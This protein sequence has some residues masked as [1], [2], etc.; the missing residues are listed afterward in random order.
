M[1]LN[2]FLSNCGRINLNVTTN[3]ETLNCKKKLQYIRTQK[4]RNARKHI[5]K[6]YDYVSRWTKLLV[7]LSK[8]NTSEFSRHDSMRL[9]YFTHNIKHSHIREITAKGASKCASKSPSIQT[10]T[11]HLLQC[12]HASRFAWQVYTY[13][14]LRSRMRRQT[15]VKPR[16]S[17]HSMLTN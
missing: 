13:Q 7:E 4:E 15:K 14:P 6:A 9:S 5:E 12:L 16:F 3:I 11:I 8:G 10:C 1:P 17:T 2:H